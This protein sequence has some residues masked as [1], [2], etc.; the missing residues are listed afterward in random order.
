MN[1]LAQVKDNP[2]LRRDLRNGSLVATPVELEKYRKQKVARIKEIDR[3]REFK[4]L[5]NEVKDLKELIVELLGKL[6][7]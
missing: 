1:N 3:D 2:D 4:T 7:K 5:K 6:D